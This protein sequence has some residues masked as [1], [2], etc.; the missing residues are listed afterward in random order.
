MKTARI[1][2]RI[3]KNLH[4][5]FVKMAQR[6]G[7]KLTPLLEAMIR[8]AVERDEAERKEPIDARQI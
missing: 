3:D 8:A 6:Q 5:R 2:M 1:H 7:M 4:A